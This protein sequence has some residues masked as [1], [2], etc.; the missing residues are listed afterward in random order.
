MLKVHFLNVGHGDCTFIEFPSGH[1]TMIDINNTKLLPSPDLAALRENMSFDAQ[2]RAAA[3]KKSWEDYYKDKMVDPIDYHREVLDGAS[4]F[5]YV[6][7]HPDL[8]HMTGLHRFFI[9][10]DVPLENMWD[11]KNSRDIPESEFAG[12]FEYLDWIQY[13]LLALGRRREGVEQ[14][15]VLHIAPGRT[16]QYWTDDGITVL[17][18][19][20]QLRAQCDAA[21][22]WNNLSYVLRIDH[23][24]RRVVL[25]GDACGRAWDDL[26][27]KWSRPDLSCDILKAAHHGRETGYH[28][29]AV[30]MMNPAAVVCSVGKKPETDASDEYASHGAKVF[31]T[32]YHGTI[33]LTLWSDGEAWLNSRDSGE[34]LLRLPPL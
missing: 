28:Q 15:K 30:S 33:T 3:Q 11:V 7:T 14:H 32:R 29:E 34:R 27:A 17:G 19:S 21:E 6:Q 16:G 12:P 25:P 24:G 9:Q 5:R 1:L 23:G 31:S 4:I 26:L 18:P 20:E 10:E 22:D 2:I 13:R 8:D